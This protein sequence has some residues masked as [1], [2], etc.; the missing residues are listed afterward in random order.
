MP[1]AT[2]T[3]NPVAE[4]TVLDAAGQPIGGALVFAYD[5]YLSNLEIYAWDDE[6]ITQLASPDRLC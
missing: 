5:G 2:V 3:D 6:Q 4:A 1:S